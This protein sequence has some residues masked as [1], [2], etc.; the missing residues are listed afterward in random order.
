MSG[1]A[2]QWMRNA[3]CV[4]EDPELFFAPNE[5]RRGSAQTDQARAV[6]A[7]CAERE[8]CLDLAV[9][10]NAEYGI[11]GG[12]SPREV[13]RLRRGNVRG[14]GFHLPTM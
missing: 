3:A 7:G 5:S 13:G 11:W 2:L 12:F 4:H 9:S 1:G 14:G 10:T 8:P 6:C